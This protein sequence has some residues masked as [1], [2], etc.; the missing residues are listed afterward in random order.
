MPRRN[1]S[2]RGAV[3][4]LV[5]VLII[6]LLAMVA[7]AIDYG[8]LLKIRTDLRNANDAAALAGALELT[9][10]PDG[11]QDYDAVRAKVRNYVAMHFGGQFTVNDSDIE[12]GKYD[13]TTVYDSVDLLWDDPTT[14]EDG[15]ADT[16]RVTLRRDE[17]A[18]GPVG[19]FF[20]KSLGIGG[21]SMSTRSTAI[22]RRALGLTEGA[23]ILPF[24]VPYDEFKDAPDGSIWNIY[25]D[26]RLEDFEGNQVPG[27]W[28]TVDIGLTNNSTADLR[29]Q[30]ENGLRQK[31]IDALYDD[32]RIANDKYIGGREEF[33]A[34]ADP[35]LS[36]GIKH[37]LATRVG[38]SGL[39]PLIDN[40][41][42]KGGNNV[43]YHVVGWGAVELVDYKIAGS[44]K[45]YVK[46]EKAPFYY[47]DLYPNN[48]LS[49]SE[50]II[51][52]AF[53]YPALIE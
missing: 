29:D 5:A 31:D 22:I 30:I 10:A 46:I 25:G 13:A 50:N 39:V 18:N 52:G 11:T 23:M 44:K 40:I 15:Y 49:D 51:E 47:S 38:E 32:G 9:P 21:S 28:G 19:V 7:L 1:Q 20:G 17:T 3:A 53:T 37:A 16:V 24:V 33:W 43:E 45:S 35:G 4:V 26:G 27:N 36:G 8:Y 2:R 14:G 48:D 34:N 42:G 12:I 6:P 41:A